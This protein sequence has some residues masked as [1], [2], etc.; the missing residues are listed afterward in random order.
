MLAQAERLAH[1]PAPL[2]ARDITLLLVLSVVAGLVDV[3]GFLSLGNIFTAHITG[4]LVLLAAHVANGGSPPAAQLWSIPVFAAAV[5]LA[6][7]LAHRAGPA[8]GAKA[9]L[10]VQSLLLFLVLGLALR[11]DT[12]GVHFGA[13]VFAPAMVAVAAMAFQN[14][15]MRLAI[16]EGATTVMTGNVAGSV[17]AALALAWSAPTRAEAE[18][19]L[20][21]TL[22]PVIGFFG[23]CVLGAATLA[24]VGPWAWMLPALLSLFAI[25]RR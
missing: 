13:N 16:H 12:R 5:A 6:W 7:L 18:E 2:P 20:R 10:L 11:G 21:Q 23:G 9:L 3:T 24:Q 22:P 4:N 15:F 25:S 1:E 19:K 8:V 14:A 17:I